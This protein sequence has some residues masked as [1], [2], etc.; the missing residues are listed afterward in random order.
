MIAD[1]DKQ[2][3][4]HLCLVRLLESPTLA[5]LCTL[6]GKAR[7][8][9]WVARGVVPDLNRAFAG[10]PHAMIRDSSI[11]LRGVRLQITPKYK[12]LLRR[13]VHTL[14]QKDLSYMP[15][16]RINTFDV[17]TDAS[18]EMGGIASM[19][20]ESPVRRTV[21]FEGT[22][23]DK[24]GLT[25]QSDIMLKELFVV[26][27]AVKLS[28]RDCNLRVWVDSAVNLFAFAKGSSTRVDRPFKVLTDLIVRTIVTKNISLTMRYVNTKENPADL[29]SRK[30]INPL[31]LEAGAHFDTR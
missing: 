23:W 7:H 24:A 16:V 19:T 21:R 30:L 11:R 25:C 28:P 12:A 1:P 2:N 13:I 22:A 20:K 9:S 18:L 29:P 3:G 17:A 27:V 10:L 26:L 6:L 14:M 4:L 8:M 5:D 31:P 15:K